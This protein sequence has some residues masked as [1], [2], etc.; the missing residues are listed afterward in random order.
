[1]M[2][3]RSPL[4]RAI[5]LGSSKEGV[6][7]WWWQRVTSVALVPLS[8][9][10]VFSLASLA[11]ADHQTVVEW[12]RSPIVASLLI[13]FVLTA[14][15]HA[16]LGVQVIIEDYVHTEWLKMTSLIGLN[17]VTL[18]ITLVA[19]VLLLRIAVGV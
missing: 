7:H 13:M 16:L 5:G 10:F 15:Y 14:F 12:M 3:L 9:W 11:G 19:A 17:F 4:G 18:L 6:S 1:M 2:S 8:V